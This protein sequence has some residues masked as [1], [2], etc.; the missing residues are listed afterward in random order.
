M[1]C[2]LLRALEQR[3]PDLLWFSII[4]AIALALRFAFV[5]WLDPDP[6]LAGVTDD[7]WFYNNA[8]NALADGRGYISPGRG[9]PTAQWP[10]GYPALLASVYLLPGPDVTTGKILNVLL[11]TLSCGLLFVAGRVLW[12]RAVGIAAGLLLA[13]FPSH[14]FYSTLILTETA[15]SALVTACILFFIWLLLRGPTVHLGFQVLLGLALGA[16]T[17]IR[18]EAVLLPFVFAGTWAVSARSFK[19]GALFAGAALLGLAIV[20]SGWTARNIVQMGAAIPVSTGSSRMAQAHWDGADGGPSHARVKELNAKFPDV[21]FPEREVKIS[22]QSLRDGLHFMATH[23]LKELSLFPRRLYYL[24][25]HDHSAL[26]LISHKP[27]S[28]GDT[29]L[30][31]LRTAANVYYFSAI[32]LGILGCRLWWQTRRAVAVLIIGMVVSLSVLI[33]VLYAGIERYHA[34]L[35]PTICLAAAP[36]IIRA[37]DTLRRAAGLSVPGN[38][39]DDLPS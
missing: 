32:A 17:L 4:V 16:A 30:D 8:A 39:S 31:R 38:L 22:Q 18:G 23:P 14:I 5:M 9:T 7:S 25:R 6:R 36:F 34:S 1:R 37:S 20:L 19:S 26:D 13:F 12:N 3:R 27:V 11:G 10:P 21:P 35:I 2:S 24:F 15:Y 29:G 28:L 33:G